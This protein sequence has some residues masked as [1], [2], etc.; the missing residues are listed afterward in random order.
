MVASQFTKLASESSNKD[1]AIESNKK[2]PWQWA[3]DIVVWTACVSA[4]V[5]VLARTCGPQKYL[6]SDTYESYET[7]DSIQND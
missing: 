4:L 5:W 2:K 1:K 7:T 3:L 6:S